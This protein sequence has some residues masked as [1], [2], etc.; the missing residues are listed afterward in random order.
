M[1]KDLFT[2]LILLLAG[3]VAAQQLVLG[4][5]DVVRLGVYPQDA[6]LLEADAGSFYRVSGASYTSSDHPLLGEAVNPDAQT[7]YF[8]KYDKE[9]TPLKSNYVK[10][11]NTP[12]YAGSYQGG[13]TLMASADLEVDASGTIIPIP[14]ASE[15]EFLAS[16]DPDCQLVRIINIWALTDNQ[17]MNSEAVMDPEDGSIY[18]YGKASMPVEHRGF[19][20]MAKNLETPNS[21]FYLI[22]YDHSLDLEWVY[23]AG[24]DL[25]QSGTSPS[26]DRIQVFPGHDGGVLITGS[27]GSESSP[28][29]HGR[30]LPSYSDTKATFAVSLD[31]SGQSRWVLDGV[32]NGFAYSTRIFKAFPLPGGDFVLAGNTSTGYYK[33]G[34]TEFSFA[35]ASSN[36]QFVFRIDA[37]GNPVWKRP[38]DSQGPSQEGKKK[39]TASEVLD[40]NIYYDA[41]SWKNRIL[42]LTAPFKN[43]VFAV[44]AVPMNLSYPTGIYVAALDIWDGSDLW[45]YALS[46]D[47]AKIYGFDVDRS[48]NVS[49]MGYN[50]A[51]Q[52]LD[53]IVSPAVVA[54]GFLFHVGLDYHGKPLWYSNTSLLTE[55]YSDLYG[56]DLEVLPDGEVFS[57]V[58]LQASNEL[59]IGESR[60]STGASAYTSWLLEL[61]SD[62]TLGG[63]VT[64]AGAN[65]VYPGYVKAMKSTWWGIYPRVDSVWL[66]DDGSYLFEGLYP[67]NYALLAVPDRE[68]YPGALPTYYGNETGWKSALFQDLVPKYTSNTMHIQLVDVDPSGSGL[69]SMSGTISLEETLDDALKGTRARPSPKSSVILLKKNKKSTLAGEVVAYVE[70]DEFGMFSFSDVPDGEYLLHVEVTGLEML[71]IHDVT[72]AGN[73]IVSGLNYTI[74]EEGI[75]IGYPVG[76]SLLENEELTIYPNPGPGLIMMDLPA[77]GEYELRVFAADG[78]LILKEAFISSGG[79]RTI[80]LSGAGDGLYFIRLEGPDTDE[81]LKYIKR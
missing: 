64:D 68:Q 54:G 20:T 18:V 11:T 8:I 52:D 77:A 17:F 7:I 24:F 15:V 6:Y 56:V 59:V 47:D 40:N 33:L 32:I 62:V 79:A 50:Y 44:N 4:T 63:V 14:S 73:Q 60:L 3:S 31:W 76:M 28:L 34:E 49:L 53:G 37:S 74:G 80:H 21:Y 58:K 1:K 67:G 38:F 66:K 39:S 75:Y 16:Y 9:G 43:Q 65:P 81:T 46:S 19:G 41:L 10:G 27:Y 45:G 71:Q 25:D 29:I 61:A 5:H 57:S 12:V 70:T 23:Q 72:I 26:Y 35:D 2:A 22:K 48:G 51:S 13:F 42:Y 69:G 36:N 55:P 78:R 30:S